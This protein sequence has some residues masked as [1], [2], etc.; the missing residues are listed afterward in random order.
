MRNLYYYYNDGTLI[1]KYSD[2]DGK[3]IFHRYV[4][5]TLKEAIKKFRQDFNL[6]HKHI[7][8]QKLY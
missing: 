7:Q 1:I 4:F 3:R 2:D 8:V 5:Y 6:Q